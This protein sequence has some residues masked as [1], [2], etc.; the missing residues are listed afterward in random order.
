MTEEVKQEEA[1]VEAPA[2]PGLNINDLAFMLKMIDVVT[3][4]GG[5][6]GGELANVGT[7]RNKLETFLRANVPAEEAEPTGDDDAE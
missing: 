2:A 1:A 6:R 3:E 5:F 7:I 4:R